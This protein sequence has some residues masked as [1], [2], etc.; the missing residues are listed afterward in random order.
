MTPYSFFG[1]DLSGPF[2]IPS[3]I[4]MTEP[5][6]IKL[7]V[8][9][10]PELGI[11]TTKSIG[12][13]PRL[14]NKEPIIA[15]YTPNSFINAVGLANPGVDA[16]AEKIKD[17]N[18]SPDRFLL[19]SIFGSTT[20]EITKV[21]AGLAPHVDGLELNISC[22]HSDKYGMA[23]GQDPALVEGLTKA[24]VQYTKPVLVKGQ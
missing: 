1:K 11:I 22:P 7:L 23:C 2:T 12:P 8:K 17:L 21:A 10:I 19:A 5:Q 3:G 14:G 15:Q 24:A 16:F 20:G 6:T 9:E 18:L 4:V 13:E